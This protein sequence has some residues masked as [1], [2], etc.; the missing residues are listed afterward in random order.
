MQAAFA[1]KAKKACSLDVH[2][3]H[4]AVRGMHVTD[5]DVALVPQRVIRQ[6]VALQV[7]ADSYADAD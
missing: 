6:A 5:G 3:G 4:P 7:L 2:A 1:F